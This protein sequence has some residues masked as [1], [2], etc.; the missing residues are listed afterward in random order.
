MRHGLEYEISQLLAKFPILR[1]KAR[2]KFL[3]LYILALIKSRKVQFCET[4]TCLNSQVKDSSNETRIQ[5][6]YREVNLDYDQLA[7]LFLC[8]FPSHQKLDIIIDRTEWDFGKY[9]C[10]ILMVIIS[11]R[12]INIPLYWELL[13]NKSGNSST[14][15]RIDLLS[16]C[17]QILLPSRISIVLGD[18]EFVGHQWFKYLKDNKICFCFRIPKHHQIIQ[19]DADMNEQIMF[20]S[21]LQNKYIDGIYLQNVFVDGICGN[22]SVS[23]DKDG[24][25]LFLFSNY[26]SQYLNKYYKRRWSIEAF[27]QNIKGRGF[28]LESSHLSESMKLKKLVACVSLAYVLCVNVGLAHHKKVKNIK[29]KSHGRK[30]KS[31]FRKGLDIIRNLVKKSTA[32]EKLLRRLI[33]M[34]CIKYHSIIK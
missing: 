12:V 34:L 8:V 22:V 4:A 32:L 24:E 17:L 25:L 9:Q 13:D 20:A 29:V 16:K 21:D 27:F 28:D 23:T 10:N 19:Y 11:N 1:N 6:F 31:F 2:R 15:N 3:S 30:S 14:Q 5:D 7:L 18:R 33:R 26:P